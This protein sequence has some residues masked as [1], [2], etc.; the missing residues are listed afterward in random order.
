VSD[1]WQTVVGRIAGVIS[2]LGFLP[3]VVAVLRRKA[4]PNRATW[5]IW[6]A[7]GGLLF[8]SYDASA[9]GS[10]RW[11][12]LSDALGPLMIAVL[13]LRYGEGGFTR[14][15]RG[16]LMLAAV[17]VVAW[18]LTGSALV[19]LAI[20]LFIDLLGA[21]PTMRKAYADPASESAL[22]WRI[23][24]FGNVL[25]LLAIQ[26]WNVGSAA[27][28]I[29]VVLVSGIVNVLL[30]AGKRAEHERRRTRYRRRRPRVR[31]RVR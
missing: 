21:L 19:A 14:F 6:T 4:R 12:P 29:Y 9:G 3:Y 31:S 13:S 16:C 22:T 20:N 5:L 2:L 18:A 28:P 17:S 25:N 24:L 8:A 10:A 30:V 23:F 26:R 11:V 27:Y 7:V 15:D 1:G